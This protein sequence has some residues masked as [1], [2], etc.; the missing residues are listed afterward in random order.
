MSNDYATPDKSHRF[1]ITPSQLLLFTDWVTSKWMDSWDSSPRWTVGLK[2]T[3]RSCLKEEQPSVCHIKSD[4]ITASCAAARGFLMVR[5]KTP[6]GCHRPIQS[7]STFL[8]P[9]KR[10][11]SVFLCS[12]LASSFDKTL[13]TCRIHANLLINSSQ[14]GICFLSFYLILF[15]ES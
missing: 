3:S 15:C 14:G 8:F 6:D 5:R 4:R 13:L 11:N 10:A 7:K 9:R 12:I 1:P 2:S